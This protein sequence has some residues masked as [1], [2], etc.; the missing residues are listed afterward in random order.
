MA[1]KANKELYAQFLLATF[2]RHSAVWLSEL[3]DREPAHDSFTRWLAKTKLRPHILW[4]YVEPMV[5]KTKGF[6]VVDDSVLDK[7]YARDM[8]LVQHLYSGTHH[9]VVKGI[10]LVSLV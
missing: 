5:D 7:W 6:L 2:G 9:R 4:E 1:S 8:A 10:G 3:L